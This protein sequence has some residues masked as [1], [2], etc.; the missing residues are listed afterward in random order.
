MRC[1]LCLETPPTIRLCGTTLLITQIHVSKYREY[2]LSFVKE[3]QFV[4]VC[5]A[6]LAAYCF[7]QQLS[8]KLSVASFCISFGT[9]SNNYRLLSSN[10]TWRTE[11]LPKPLKHWK[12]NKIKS[13][14]V[15]F[16]TFYE[17]IA[18]YGY[19]QLTI[20][21]VLSLITS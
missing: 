8:R 11:K 17:H 6:S 19:E 7:T 20:V 14:C 2:S 21:I 3:Y 13:T 10:V 18:Q 16:W 12:I 9:V 15:I 1:F 4:F 5:I